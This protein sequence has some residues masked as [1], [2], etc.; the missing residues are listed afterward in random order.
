MPSRSARWIPSRPTSAPADFNE[1]VNTIG[2]PLYAKQEPRKFD[3]AL[4][5]RRATRCRCHRL[6]C[7]I[8]LVAA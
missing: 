2:Q 6:A 3:R 8:K 7:W 5:S 1:T 4:I